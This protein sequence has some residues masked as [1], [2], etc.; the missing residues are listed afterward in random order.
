MVT[1]HISSLPGLIAKWARPGQLRRELHN[2]AGR[3]ELLSED[4]LSFLLP[5]KMQLK[6]ERMEVAGYRKVNSYPCQLLQVAST[7]L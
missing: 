4:S 5:G 6:K 3:K 2:C 1:F 7:S